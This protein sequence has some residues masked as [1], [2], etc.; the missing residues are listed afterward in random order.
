MLNYNSEPH[1]SFFRTIQGFDYLLVG[2]IAEWTMAILYIGFYF[3]FVREFSKVCIHFRV[4]LL[5][6]HF[7]DEPQEANVAVA[8]EHTPIVM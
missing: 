3:T 5:V 1:N 2:A 6:Q 7:D 4:Q 8:T